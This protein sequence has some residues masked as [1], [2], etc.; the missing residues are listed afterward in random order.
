VAVTALD[1]HDSMKILE[2]LGLKFERMI[3]FPGHPEESR[4]FAYHV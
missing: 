4:L 2:R 3:Q 1:N